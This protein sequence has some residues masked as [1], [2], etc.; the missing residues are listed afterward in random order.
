MP[1]NT[2][3]EVKLC[4]DSKKELVLKLKGKSAQPKRVFS[5]DG[6]E[7][8]RDEI[9]KIAHRINALY[10]IMWEK[11]GRSMLISQLTVQSYRDPEFAGDE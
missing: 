1:S 3:T 10:E 11:Y 8:I 6:I 4:K 7:H 9:R 5:W 2:K